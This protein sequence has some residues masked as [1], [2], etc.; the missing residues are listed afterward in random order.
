[1]KNLSAALKAHYASGTTS[2][3]TCWKATLKNGTVVA[4]T[5]HDRNIVFEGV[6]YLAVAAYTPTDVEN[7]SDMSPDNLEIE[8]FLASPAITD[9]DIYSGKW[10]YAAIEMFEVNFNDLTMGRN[11]VRSGTLGEVRAG[12]SKFTAELRGLMQAYSRRIVRLTTKECT[13]DLGDARCTVNLT[14]YTA[15]GSVEAIVDN[16]T[17]TSMAGRDVAMN[18]YTGGLITFTSGLNSGLSMEIKRSAGTRLELQE[19]M[20]FAIAKRD[21]FTIRAGCMKRYYED[22][23]G[24]FNNRLN[25]RGFPHL[26]GSGVFGGPGTMM[27]TGGGGTVIPAAPP[28]PAPAPPPAS[29][30]PPAPA[31]APAPAP[32]GSPP[33]MTVASY[34]NTI[35]Q[36]GADANAYWVFDN[37]WGQG[38]IVEGTGADQFQQWVGTSATI[39]PLGEVAARLKWRWPD[40]EPAGSNEVKSYPAIAYGRKPGLY[41]TWRTPGGMDVQLLD[42]S[43]SG[44]APS[45]WTPGTFLPQR[46]PLASLKANSARRWV[47]S[48]TGKGHFSYDIWL[49]SSATQDHGFS[50]SSVTHEIMIPLEYWGGYGAHPSGRNPAWYDHDVTIGGIL[51]HVYCAKDLYRDP[52]TGA[53]LS[54]PAPGLNYSFGGL[55]GTY[56]RYGWKFIVFEP[57]A[58][59]VP[60]SGANLNLAAF[61]AHVATRVDSIGQAWATGTEWVSSVE[62]GIEPQTGSGD[63]ELFDFRVYT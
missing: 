45:G 11:L 27:S 8:G 52:V 28:A 42:G 29:P 30:T 43:I 13:A 47:T 18:W 4:A 7:A 44:A 51:Y 1:V 56:G 22:C 10:D 3:A 48:P 49:Q 16:R 19:A 14:P 23:I 20:P 63:L 31:P 36:T 53:D 46:C 40:P 6:T 37:R 26:P 25:F 41:N 54:S 34:P 12:K 21:T 5:S 55:D 15:T 32:S 33:T 60:L 35:L 62:L 38:S 57:D 50:A 61:I 59:H 2:I 58:A 24:K 17:I 9:N 39:G